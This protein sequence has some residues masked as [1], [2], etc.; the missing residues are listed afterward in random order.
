ML[1]AIKAVLDAEEQRE[2]S[3]LVK[4]WLDRLQHVFYDAEDVLDELECEALRKQVMSR[5]GGVKGKVHRFLSL[6]NPLIL[7]A[8]LSRKV[9]EI[10][11][12]LSRISAEKDRLDLKVR[13]ADN[14]V[15]RTQTRKMTY[16]F[17]NESDVIGRDIDKE[18]I[19]EML[20][21]PD[22]DLW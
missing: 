12:A 13:G 19:I 4:V 2:K 6:S 11:E 22:K 10:W 14:D 18:K 8:K 3:H 9:K 20:V 16:S 1:I 7:R 21:Q 15:A 17:V 5:Y